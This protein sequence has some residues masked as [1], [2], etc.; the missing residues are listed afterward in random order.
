MPPTFLVLF[1]VLAVVVL[2]IGLVLLAQSSRYASSSIPCSKYGTSAPQKEPGMP[3]AYHA[4]SDNKCYQSTYGGAEN[5]NNCQEPPRPEAYH[6]GMAMAGV[7]AVC[8]LLACCVALR[9][10]RGRKAEQ[11]FQKAAAPKA[12]APKA[13]APDA[14]APKAGSS[15]ATPRASQ[16]RR[17][18]TVNNGLIVFALVFY[19]TCFGEKWNWASIL[20][21]LVALAG[22]ILMIFK[23]EYREEL[24][25]W[26]VATGL[27][28][29]AVGFSEDKWNWVSILGTLVALGGAG[30]MIFKPE[31]CE[32]LCPQTLYPRIAV[33]AGF[34]VS[35]VGFTAV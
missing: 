29:G 21:T 13:A 32:K 2:A 19:F 33:L 16:R 11:G 26:I 35:A 18:L 12:A 8:L 5:M 24:G 15:P 34:I 14:A 28:V 7:A 6:A 31:Y 4:S 23:P 20:G 3:C 27:I 10:G 1:L 22:A 25:P 30:W 17:I 9:R